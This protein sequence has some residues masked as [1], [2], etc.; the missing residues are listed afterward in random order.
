[1]AFEQYLP[2]TK[3]MEQLTDKLDDIIVELE[4]FLDEAAAEDDSDEAPE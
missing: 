2:W 4:M 3:R 1:M